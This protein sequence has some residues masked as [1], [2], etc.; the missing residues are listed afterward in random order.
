MIRPHCMSSGLSPSIS[1]GADMRLTC[2]QVTWLRLEVRS[3]WRL[4]PPPA[5]FRRCRQSWGRRPASSH[6]TMKTTAAIR[7]VT[8]NVLSIAENQPM[9]VKMSPWRGRRRG[10][11]QLS[12]PRA[13]STHPAPCG[14][15]AASAREPLTAPRSARSIGR[16]T[17]RKRRSGWSAERVLSG[18]TEIAVKSWNRPV[19][20]DMRHIRIINWCS[21]SCITGRYVQL[22][23]F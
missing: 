14:S 15:R 7:A 6:T 16:C 19:S 1:S 3:R 12:G 23:G 13:Y 2:P 18:G 17:A 5:P 22:G 11:S 20:A 9:A 4:T 8:M 10:L 21:M